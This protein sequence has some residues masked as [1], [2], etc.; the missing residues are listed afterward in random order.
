MIYKFKNGLNGNPEMIIKDSSVFI[1]LD[2]RNMDCH[3]FVADWKGVVEVRDADNNIVP[4][5][6][7]ACEALGLDPAG[8]DPTP[9][10]EDE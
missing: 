5:S 9:T 4:Y 1:P 6:D 10:P 3:Q 2:I 8:I 7:A